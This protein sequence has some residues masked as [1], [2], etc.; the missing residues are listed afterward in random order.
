VSA[1]V[2]I[3]LEGG[4]GAGKTTQV[5]HL[6]MALTGAGHHVV[7]TR[8]PGDSPAGAAVRQ[9][10]LNPETEMTP[11]T[12]ALLYLADRAE[13]VATVIRPALQA[14]KIV[15]CDR[16]TDSLLAYQGAGRL[17]GSVE[18]EGMSRWAAGGLRP[19]LVILLDVPPEVGLG[20]QRASG[21]D[22]IER[23]PLAF[24]QRVRSAFLDLAHRKW[25]GRPHYEVVDASQLEGPVAAGVRDAVFGFLDRRSRNCDPEPS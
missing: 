6:A 4:E 7:V 3:A 19:D 20:R 25:A 9:L 14:G 23:E 13:H 22:R 11:R 15:L 5:A 21:A 1:G 18:L 12:E 24:H 10:L 2:F 16:Y 8:E 17:L